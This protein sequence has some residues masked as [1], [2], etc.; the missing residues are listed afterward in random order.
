MDFYCFSCGHAVKDTDVVVNRDE[1]NHYEGRGKHVFC[2]GEV[3][4]I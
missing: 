1:K 3:K 2:G 4:F